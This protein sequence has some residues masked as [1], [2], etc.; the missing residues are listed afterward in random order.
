[1]A[2]QFVPYG[3]QFETAVTQ[4]AGAPFENM[5]LYTQVTA[6]EGVQPYRTYRLGNRF[7]VLIEPNRTNGAFVHIF[8]NR[9]AYLQWWIGHMS[10]GKH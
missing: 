10:G 9:E 5:R 6:V 4:L 2:G 1:M 3:Q 7:L 8:E